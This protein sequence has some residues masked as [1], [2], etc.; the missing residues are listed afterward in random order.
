MNEKLNEQY[1]FLTESDNIKN[2]LNNILDINEINLDYLIMIVKLYNE[3]IKDIEINKMEIYQNKLSIV[4]DFLYIF[5]S[6]NNSKLY[7]L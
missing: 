7:N 2:S 5:S 6:E 1:Y 3:L 4:K